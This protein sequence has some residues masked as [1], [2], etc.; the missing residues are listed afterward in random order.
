MTPLRF[1]IVGSGWRAAFFLRVA[2][3]LPERFIVSC[4]ASRSD[5]T[6]RA[7]AQRWGVPAVTTSSKVRATR[8]DVVVGCVAPAASTPLAAELAGVGLPMLLETPAGSSAEEIV[9]LLDLEAQGARIQ[10]AEQYRFQPLHAARLAVAASGRL[11]RIEQAQVS[12]AHGYHGVSI[13]RAFLGG[14]SRT[15][16]SPPS[17]FARPSSAA[18]VAMAR[19]ARNTRSPSHSWSP[20][21]NT[22]TASAFSTSPTSS[23]SRGSDPTACWCAAGAVRSATTRCAG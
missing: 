2:A 13:L 20:G 22:P 19:P 16:A 21:S 23:T 15:R 17:T 12:V 6:R 4:I 11:G 7:A 10:V 5:E 18:P 9:A 1:A 14:G 8:P 3:A